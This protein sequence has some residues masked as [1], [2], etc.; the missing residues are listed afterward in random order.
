MTAAVMGP[1]PL[2]RIRQDQE[3]RRLPLRRA[4]EWLTNPVGP[5]ELFS[6]EVV[7]AAM[8]ALV[9]HEVT[10]AEGAAVLTAVAKREALIDGPSSDHFLQDFAAVSRE[11]DR[12]LDDILDLT[13][14]EGCGVVLE[15]DSSRTVCG[16]N[17]DVFCDDYEHREVHGRCDAGTDR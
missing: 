12:A 8:T 7:A 11:L 5:V 6:D 2:E 3:R 16:D 15:D 13:R 9:G 17:G 4:L 14:C 10:V 1:S